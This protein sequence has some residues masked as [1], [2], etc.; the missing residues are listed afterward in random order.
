MLELFTRKSIFQDNGEIYQLETIYELTGT[1]SVDERL[2]VSHLPR[3]KL[4]PFPHRIGSGTSASR[5]Q[6]SEEN[7]SSRRLDISCF[8]ME[9][10]AVLLVDLGNVEGEWH[11]CVS[12][13]ELKKNKAHRTQVP[14][15]MRR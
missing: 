12:K 11:K 14:S 5:V 8:K 10:E 13:M 3:R 9:P 1:P 2:G 7:Y 15:S 6:P 4:V